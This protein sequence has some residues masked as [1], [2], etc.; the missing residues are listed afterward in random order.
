MKKILPIFFAV[1]F[2]SSAFSQK[3]LSFTGWSFTAEAGMNYFDGDINQS[4]TNVFPTAVRTISWGGTIEYAFTPIWGLSLDYYYFPLRAI[5]GS[6]V[7]E[8]NTNMMNSDINATVNLTRLI[9][10]ETKSKLYLIASVG[11]GFARYDFDVRDNLGVP[12]AADRKDALGKTILIYE[13]DKPLKT[14]FTG[15]APATLATEYNFSKYIA[16]G[17][18]FHYRAYTKDNVEGVTR[19]NWAGVTNDYVAAGQVYLRYKLNT[20]L[21]SHK[22]NIRM[23]EYMP[24]SALELARE[25][26]ERINKLDTALNKLE[27]KVD[28]QGVRIDSIANLLCDK[29]PDTDSDC[30]PDCRDKELDTPPNSQVDFW[31]RKIT[32]LPAYTVDVTNVN[33]T[34]IPRT[35][36]ELVTNFPITYIDDIP[37]VYFDFDQIVLDDDALVTIRKVSLKMKANSSLMVE[38]R[39]YCDNVGNNPYNELLSQRRADR[40]KTEMVKIWGVAPERIFTNG[41]GKVLEPLS[42]Y[43]PNRRC[44]FFFSK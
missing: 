29:G 34:A 35:A 31:G 40:V 19:L 23:E 36:N 22:R 44:D 27:Q 4:L 17:L 2:I 26:T 3:R 5:T 7:L 38:V 39:G 32:C 33:G 11:L 41:K 30:V 24:N 10:P 28:S 8:I 25:N 20:L 42:K 13:N 43:R 14:G 12:I 18:R 15:S 16:L 1:L 9:F 6:P 37:A 21:K